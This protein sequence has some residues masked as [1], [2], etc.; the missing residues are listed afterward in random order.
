MSERQFA[1]LGQLLSSVKGGGTPERDVP[2]YWGGPIPWA[3]VKDFRDGAHVLNGTQEHISEQGLKNSASKLIPPKTPI[4]CTR[5]AVGRV[6]M[7]DF[8]VA[9]NQDL[10]ALFPKT[11]VDPDYLLRAIE[12]IRPEIEA[13]A[14][15]STVKGISLDQLLSV[16]VFFP[17]DEDEQRK[18]AEVLSTLDRAIE[19]TEALIAKQQRIKTGLMQDLLT[20]GIDEHGNIRSEATHAFKDS[21]LGRIPVEWEA[22][23]ILN[24]A[25]RTRQPILTGPF[26]AQL[27]TKDFVEEGVSLLRIGNVQAG[28]IDQ[29]DLLFVTE[30]KAADLSRYRVQA[31]DLLFARQGATTGRNSLAGASEDGYLINYH[32]IRVAVDH[33]KC[34]PVFLYAAFNSEMVQSQ[35]E[36]E[37]GKGTREGVNTA[38]LTAFVLP[39][40]CINEQERIAEVISRHSQQVEKVTELVIKLRRLKA[41]LMHDLLTGERRVTPLLL[42]DA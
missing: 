29:S 35:V 28:Y 4:V 32:I 8:S 23:S 22:G 26:G 18:I 34:S 20:K 1:P 13:T 42:G 15:G 6:A 16:E 2:E 25:S 3:T 27:G 31:G 14:I 24:Y 33:T 10:K 17:N 30:Q 36:R 5:M 11:E 21:P 7:A 37:K 12:S 9:I 38:T 19:Q 39:I 40:P 41:G